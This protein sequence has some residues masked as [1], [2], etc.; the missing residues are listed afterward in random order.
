MVRRNLWGCSKQIKSLAYTSLVGSQLEYASAVWDPHLQKHCHKLDM[1][2]R[3]GSRFVMADYRY[4]SSPSEMISKLQWQSLPVRR[5]AARLTLLYKAIQGTACIPIDNLQRPTR[6]TR[7][8]SHLSFIALSSHCDTYKF[9]F[10]PRTVTDWNNLPYAI[11]CLPSTDSF[12]LALV[13]HL[14]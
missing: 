7:N 13:S 11:H 3:R 4:T 6:T 10:Y 12:T 1:V 14:D 5:Q 9:S 8:S 2:Q